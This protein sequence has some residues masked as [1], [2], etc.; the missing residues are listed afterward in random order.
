M[1]IIVFAA[2]DGSYVTKHQL[3]KLSGNLSSPDYPN[4]YPNSAIF[5]WTIN[6]GSPYQL[7]LTVKQFNT[8][9]GTDYLKVGKR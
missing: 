2:V 5:D 8:E 4:A 9:S 1:Y 6:V 7:L 3:M